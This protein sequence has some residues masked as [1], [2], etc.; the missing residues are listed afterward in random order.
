MRCQPLSRNVA[1]ALLATMTCF[2]CRGSQSQAADVYT[3]KDSKGEHLDIVT[4]A[5]GPLLR[6]VYVR[7]KSTKEKNFDTAKVFAHVVAANGKTTLTKGQGGKFPHHRGIFIGW[8]KLQ[9]GGK[10]HDLW[11]VRNTEQLHVK[12]IEQSADQNGASITSLINW[13]GNHGEQVIGETRTYRV[14]AEA[15]AHAVIDFVS[16][17]KAV[18]GDIELNGDPEHAGVQFRPSQQVAENKSAKYVFH[19]DGIDPKKD[20]DLPWVSETFQVD[21]EPWTVQHMSH[22]SNPKGA[23]WSA[24]RDYGRFGPFTVVKI[25]AGETQTFRYRFRVSSGAAPTRQQLAARY[26][27]YAK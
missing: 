16:Q 15:D 18:N 19:K 6:Y 2:A 13:V 26:K 8:N 24:Y 3:I 25:A 17:L 14:V 27:A 7:D 21:E 12:F 23:R 9:Q 11:H 4:P 20:R 10:S 1:L 5:G 22:P